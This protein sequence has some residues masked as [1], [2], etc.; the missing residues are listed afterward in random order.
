MLQS[1]YVSAAPSRYMYFGMKAI[2]FGVYMIT[3]CSKL[4]N[5]VYPL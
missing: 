3:L 1:A 4:A 5:I 2:F